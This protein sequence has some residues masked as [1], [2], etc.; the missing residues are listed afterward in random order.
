[1]QQFLAGTETVVTVFPGATTVLEVNHFGDCNGHWGTRFDGDR[2]V[3]VDNDGQH[4]GF[5]GEGDDHNGDLADAIRSSTD[6]PKYGSVSDET[7]NVL[8]YTAPPLTAYP[9][10]A[11]T[12]DYADS[13]IDGTD[14]QERLRDCQSGFG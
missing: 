1:M 3:H 13:N 12:S 2:E 10:N 6:Y 11:D 5:D 7:Q 9:L 4:H 8:T 14:E